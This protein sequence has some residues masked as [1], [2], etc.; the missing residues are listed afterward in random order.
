[1]N[2]STV[3]VPFHPLVISRQVSYVMND[4]EQSYEA[5]LHKNINLIFLCRVRAS[6][7]ERNREANVAFCHSVDCPPDFNPLQRLSIK[8]D[9]H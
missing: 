1:M 9:A 2:F 8:M 4:Y 3:A 7:G 6:N 5:A